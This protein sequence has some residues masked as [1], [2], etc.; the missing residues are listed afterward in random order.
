MS[1]PRLQL[2]DVL[3]SPLRL[4]LLATLLDAREIEFQVVRD[5]LETTDSMLS[6]HASAL[7]AAGLITVRK[8]YVGKRPRTWLAATP[9]GRRAFNAH[10]SAL[11]AIVTAE[12]FPNAHAGTGA[13]TDTGHRTSD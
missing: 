1:H 12:A 11:L 4:S 10:R 13:A 5:L 2:L 8:G 9:V 6:K 3:N 7:E